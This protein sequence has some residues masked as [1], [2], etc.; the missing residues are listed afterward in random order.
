M[1]LIGLFILRN[2]AWCLRATLAAAAKWLDGMAIMVHASTD[3][4]AR[5]ACCYQTGRAMPGDCA[6]VR[7][8][9]EPS[10]AWD[11]ATY[12]S[13]LLAEG[14]CMGGTH[15]AIIDG[16]EMLTANLVPHIRTSAEALDPGQLIRL[17]WLNCW[18]GLDAYRSDASPFGRAYAPVVFA[19]AP[20]LSYSPEADGYQLHTRAPRGVRA[21]ELGRHAD[22]GLLHLQHANWRRL[23]AKQAL[24]QMDEVLR[25]PG[26][27]PAGEIARTYRPAVD[28]TGL[29]TTAIP[30]DWWPVDRAAID[31]EAAAWQE[32]EVARLLAL[33]GREHFAGLDL[34]GL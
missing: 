32:A 26:R 34:F 18:R 10:P 21:M 14:R 24:Y 2:E 20:H 23:C 30:A 16:D 1:K 12:R 15:F 25:W 4:T 3:A 7:H 9:I 29:E 27:R 8:W 19:D 17:P 33:H 5:I 6:E 28:E 22:G 11:E 13:A 31:L